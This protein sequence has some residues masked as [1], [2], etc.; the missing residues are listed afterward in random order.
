M[1]DRPALVQAVTRNPIE[2]AAESSK[3][4]QGTPESST[5]EAAGDSAPGQP[6]PAVPALAR[7]PAEPSVS[8]DATVI[9][10]PVVSSSVR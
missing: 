2:A 1:T 6:P 10:K 9:I 7:T 4:V 8:D 5:G 3:V